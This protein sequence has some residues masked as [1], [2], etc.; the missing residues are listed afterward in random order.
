M[1]DFPDA[2]QDLLRR[3]LA[4]DPAQP[5]GIERIKRHPAFRLGLP[6]NYTC[7][8][9]LPLPAVSAPIEPAD[10]DPELKQIFFGVGYT[11]EAELREDLRSPES[12][13][14]KAF[15]VLLS[16]H[17]S[18]DA[19][20]WPTEEED[21]QMCDDIHQAPLIL[22]AAELCFPDNVFSGG[23]SYSLAETARWDPVAFRETHEAKNAS[24]VHDIALPLEHVVAEVQASLN[25]AGFDW[26][27]PN[28][29]LIVAR[30]Q[31]QKIDLI[32]NAE[33]QADAA[34]AIT[35]HLIKGD[36]MEFSAFA[37]ALA[38]AFCELRHA[39]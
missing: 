5:I 34:V 3:L 30:N 14:A 21:A 9:P 11:S 22:S 26:F 35:V 15:C 13:M 32:L 37:C 33:Y 18:F 25:R 36:A 16:D 24:S 17:G 31:R 28:D 38:E 19:L 2:V 1:P 20:P 39:T 12:T 7:P 4:V 23:S 10:L 29:F 27:Y 6:K 8:S